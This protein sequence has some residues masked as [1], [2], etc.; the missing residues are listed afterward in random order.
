MFPDQVKR[1]AAIYVARRRASS[2]MEV[3]SVYFTN[4]QVP[5]LF[6]VRT[7]FSIEIR[8]KTFY[9]FFPVKNGLIAVKR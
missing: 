4:D 5:L 8:V 1:D 6:E 7:I 3:S 2:N 9:F